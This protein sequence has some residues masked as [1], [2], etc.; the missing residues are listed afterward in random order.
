MSGRKN[1]EQ[2]KV[3]IRQTFSNPNIG[4]THQITLKDGPRAYRVATIFEIL[5]GK[6]GKFHHYSLRMDAFNVDQKGWVT[7]E[8]STWI[9]HD[10]GELERLETFINSV[11]NGNFRDD[12]GVFYIV[13]E[14]TYENLENVIDLVS[15]ST[16]PEKLSVMKSILADIDFIAQDSPQGIEDSEELLKNIAVAAR[17]VNYRRAYEKLRILVF[18]NTREEHAIQGVLAE[19]PWL[20]G[21]E[22]SELIPRRTWTRDDRLDFMLRRSIDGYLEIIEIKTPFPEALMLYDQSHNSYY[23]SARLSP[24]IGQVMHYIEEVERQ[25]DHIVAYEMVMIL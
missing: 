24:V 16:L 9:T 10:P 14:Y 5:D 2:I 20:F 1:I 18:N 6:T 21:S 12:D 15:E 23:P 22:Y 8:K 7:E 13:P 17:M 19:H 25:R 4:K 3:E 11:V